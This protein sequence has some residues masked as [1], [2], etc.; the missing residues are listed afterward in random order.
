[1]RTFNLFRLYWMRSPSSSLCDT[2]PV[3]AAQLESAFKL[4]LSTPA[5]KTRLGVNMS[6]AFRNLLYRL[7][8]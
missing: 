3:H 2:L 1:M 5:L 6:T 4:S 8:H 7:K